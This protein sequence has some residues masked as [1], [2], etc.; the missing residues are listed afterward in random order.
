M[1]GNPLLRLTRDGDKGLKVTETKRSPIAPRARPI[2]ERPRE[3]R[4]EERAL[5]T[6]ILPDRRFD[7]AAS[8]LV[9]GFIFV[10]HLVSSFVEM[11]LALSRVEE[12]QRTVH[13]G[14]VRQR[15]SPACREEQA[16]GVT[17]ELARAVRLGGASRSTSAG[18]YNKNTMGCGAIDPT[19]R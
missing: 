17:V 4:R 12:S 13:G 8:Q 5:L 14:N 19:A 6:D 1:S 15:P 9:R 10:S 7:V 11:K 2:L 3:G 18:G 16:A